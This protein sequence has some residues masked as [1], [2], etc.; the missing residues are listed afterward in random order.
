MSTK[1]NKAI[2]FAQARYGRNNGS[3]ETENEL[4]KMMACKV[5]YMAGW[6]AAEEDLSVAW[7]NFHEIPKVYEYVLAVD[8]KNGPYLIQLENKEDWEEWVDFTD[9][10]RWIY[11]KDVICKKDV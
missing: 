7:H 2:E 9:M 10:E 8:K 5:G 11:L 6:E 3:E 1:E 4:A